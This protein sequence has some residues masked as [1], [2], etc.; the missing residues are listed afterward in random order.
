M[1]KTLT[2]LK[3]GYLKAIDWIVAHPH[4]TFWAGSGVAVLAVVGRLV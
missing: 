1:S 3:D 4:K 2:G